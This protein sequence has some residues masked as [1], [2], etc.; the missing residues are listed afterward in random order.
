MRKAYD[1]L[2][3]LVGHQGDECITYPFYRNDEGYGMVRLDGV[4]YKATA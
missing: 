3:S 4:A 2:V 1:F